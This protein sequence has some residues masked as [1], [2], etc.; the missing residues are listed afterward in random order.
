MDPPP[1]IE[2]LIYFRN[3]RPSISTSCGSLTYGF[4]LQ[5]SYHVAAQSAS[6]K[7]SNY[8]VHLL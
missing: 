4:E 2:I 6:V 8:G 7:F 1:P 5:V 3:G